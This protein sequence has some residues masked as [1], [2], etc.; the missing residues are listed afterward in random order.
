MPA[1]PT[2]PLQ[3]LMPELLLEVFPNLPADDYGAVSRVCRKWRQISVVMFRQYLA[4]R[5][6][7]QAYCVHG[8]PPPVRTKY[9]L[10]G[11][12]CY[13]LSRDYLLLSGDA[14]IQLSKRPLQHCNA[15]G[16]PE[17]EATAP[18]PLL[19]LSKGVCHVCHMHRDL[20]MVLATDSIDVHSLV[21]GSLLARLRPVPDQVNKGMKFTNI[22][23]CHVAD[24]D[25]GGGGGEYVINIACKMRPGTNGGVSHVNL[26]RLRR[27]GRLM[28]TTIWDCALKKVRACKANGRYF[29][30]K[31]MECEP[32]ASAAAPV[33]EVSKVVAYDGQTGQKVQ[34]R[35]VRKDASL[36]GVDSV[37]VAFFVQPPGDH[38]GVVAMPNAW[39]RWTNRL[40]RVSGAA[41]AAAAAADAP[42]APAASFRLIKWEVGLNR[43]TD[44]ALAVTGIPAPYGWPTNEKFC[45]ALERD[46]CYLADHD[47]VVVA[48]FQRF[49]APPDFSPES[50]AA[51]AAAGST[52]PKIG[53]VCVFT[54][55][56]HLLSTL[57][58]SVP[59]IRDMAS[60]PKPASLSEV[61]AAAAAE[62]E[63]DDAD[64]AVSPQ[65]SSPRG[66]LVHG[67]DV[68]MDVLSAHASSQT[69]LFSVTLTSKSAV[70][71]RVIAKEFTP[72]VSQFLPPGVLT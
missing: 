44:D 36:I 12:Y 15:D 31:G 29:V 38:A 53:I 41:D 13:T 63:A 18:T 4:W 69:V 23:A 27:N 11:R 32:T 10:Y 67:C 66:A 6:Q 49:A 30:M 70:S 8:A 1:T 19:T 72:A 68:S 24:P 65:V 64:G 59:S 54:K 61:A 22:V 5:G 2:R 40:M 37:G 25:S 60:L 33:V 7:G 16:T 17:A 34:C 43:V 9:H 55:S 47:T 35:D 56:G 58:A 21:S 57:D 62:A 45:I 14:H 26:Y 48:F 51:A 39:C 28:R 52:A 50:C 71:T 46:R 20:L 3:Q 42:V